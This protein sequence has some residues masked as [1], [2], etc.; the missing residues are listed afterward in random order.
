MDYIRNCLFGS[1]VQRRQNQLLREE[2]ID[3][4]LD[5]LPCKDIVAAYLLAQRT[6]NRHRTAQYEKCTITTCHKTMNN[7][8]DIIDKELSDVEVLLAKDNFSFCRIYD[9]Y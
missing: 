4:K 2:K 6:M 3:K 8:L 9:N 1:Y 5:L 7:H